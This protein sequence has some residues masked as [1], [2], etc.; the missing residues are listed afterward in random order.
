M[1]FFLLSPFPSFYGSSVG[2]SDLSHTLYFIVAYGRV[3][4]FIYVVV[5]THIYMHTHKHLIVVLT[6]DHYFTHTGAHE[7]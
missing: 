2:F 5:Y 6:I 1:L 3:T 7:L 4:G